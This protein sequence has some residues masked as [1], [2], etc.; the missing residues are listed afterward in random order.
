MIRAPLI[1][2]FLI[3]SSL[4]FAQN[5]AGKK[6][7]FNESTVAGMSAKITANCKTDYDKVRAIFIWVSENITYNTRSYSRNKKRKSEKVYVEPVDT[8]AELT[9]LVE[10]VAQIVLQRR[11]AV[12][13]GYTKLFKSLCD[14]AGIQN[15]IISGYG[16]TN[17]SSG[18]F[19]TNHNW[20]AVYIDSS[21]HLLDVTWAAGFILGGDFIR[22]YDDSYF[23]TP[24]QYFIRDHYPEDLRWT[25]MKDPPM[26]REFYQ[27]PFKYGEFLKQKMTSYFP[28]RGI[29]DAK[30]GDTLQF[31]V[32]SEFPNFSFSVTDS[33]QDDENYWVM[34]TAQNNK[35]SCSYVVESENVEWL[36]L[37]CNNEPVLRYRLNVK[38][39]H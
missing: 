13:D 25:L 4:I 24:P 38:K 14:H 10:H 11:T 36:Y 6:N 16:I 5:A 27:S 7:Y 2:L 23:F 18:K 17:Y 19:K 32:E 20:N 1:L 8:S 37:I 21:W 34:T 15:E 9:P 39:N 26:P 28:S 30:V 12:C 35:A 3:F 31:N 22:R 33:L 29:I